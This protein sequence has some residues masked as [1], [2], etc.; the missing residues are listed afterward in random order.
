MPS[1][2]YL[3]DRHLRAAGGESRPG[4]RRLLA[5]SRIHA[6]SFVACAPSHSDVLQ[7]ASVRHGLSASL[8]I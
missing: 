2:L 5:P 3:P 4:H 8:Y 7:Y 1:L 6:Y